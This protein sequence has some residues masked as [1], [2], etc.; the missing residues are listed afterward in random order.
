MGKFDVIDIAFLSL[1]TTYFI[2][3]FLILIILINN[4]A[5]SVEN[6]NIN[7]RYPKPLLESDIPQKIVLPKYK[8][9][10]TNYL[11]AIWEEFIAYLKKPSITITEVKKS[12]VLNKNAEE[13]TFKKEENVQKVPYNKTKRKVNVKN[14]AKKKK[15][16]KKKK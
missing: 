7:K 8:K 11:K 3:L 15:G 6:V 1:I 2:A 13:I 10:K 12:K 14:Y 5:I 4:K 9:E 16:K